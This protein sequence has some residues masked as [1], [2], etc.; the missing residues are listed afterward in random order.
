MPMLSGG[1]MPSVVEREIVSTAP[2]GPLDGATLA[3]ADGAPDA[4]ATAKALAEALDDGARDSAGEPLEQPARTK[5]TAA[6]SS[7]ALVTPRS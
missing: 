2:G 4:D 3:S 1:R 6:V 7:F 5:A